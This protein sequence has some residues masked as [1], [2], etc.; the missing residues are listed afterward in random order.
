[1]KIFKRDNRSSDFQ[2]E[3]DQL[4]MD[5]LFGKINNLL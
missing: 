1:M 5:V 2:K 3:K 4:V